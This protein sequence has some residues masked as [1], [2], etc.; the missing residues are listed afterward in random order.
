[1]KK[2]PKWLL[3]DSVFHLLMLAGFFLSFN[4]DY[5]FIAALVGLTLPI[6]LKEINPSGIYDDFIRHQSRKASQW[7]IIFLLVYL[8]FSQML[9][10]SA[11]GA[12]VNSSSV[13]QLPLI[14]VV[15]I[16]FLTFTG[17]FWDG[18]PAARILLI[19]F[20]LFWSVF[21]VLSDWGQWESVL[22]EIGAISLPFIICGI[23]ANRFP[24]IVG[25]LCCIGAVLSLFF[26]NLHRGLTGDTEYWVVFL[27][28]PV[29]LFF[30]GITLL[31]SFLGWK[32]EAE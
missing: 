26:F 7:A 27:M 10:D 30:T 6:I 29:P 16:R 23:L 5:F 2:I 12:A 19:I 14:L 24:F 28:I 18:K 25:I 11:A 20:G 1:M 8:P 13:M 31:Q 21:I 15:V 4:H 32:R 3:V 22:F 17:G 9:M